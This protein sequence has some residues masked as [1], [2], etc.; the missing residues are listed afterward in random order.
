MQTKLF[1]FWTLSEYRTIW[2]WAKSRSYKILTCQDFG[3]SYNSLGCQTNFSCFATKAVEKRE[4]QKIRELCTK[5]PFLLLQ[6]N[7]KAASLAST[8]RRNNSNVGPQ[9]IE[10]FVDGKKVLVD[11]G[12]TVLQVTSSYFKDVTKILMT[13]PKFGDFRIRPSHTKLPVKVHA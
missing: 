4:S 6:T 8:S 13:S 12:T 3:R 2:K 9:K 1:R 11:P 5:W 10:C 7:A